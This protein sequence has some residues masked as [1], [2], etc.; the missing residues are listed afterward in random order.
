MAISSNEIN[1]R[2]S[3]GES[4]TSP[5]NSIGGKISLTSITDGVLNN[6][7]D[8][9]SDREENEEITDYR[10]IYILN[11]SSTDTFYD[12]GVWVDSQEPGGADITIG[13]DAVSE[14]QSITIFPE[15][16][17]VGGFFSLKLGSESTG[18][19][20]W[21]D[22]IDQMSQN[23]LV[24]LRATALLSNDIS[25]NSSISS[26]TRNFSVS[27]FGQEKNKTFPLMV[28]NIN[29]LVRSNNS[30]A[31]INTSKVQ[32]GKPIN[33]T[34]VNIGFSNNTPNN[35]S[36]FE[37]SSSS[38]L[39]IGVLKPNDFCYIWIRR[40]VP[41]YAANTDSYDDFVLKISGFTE[42]DYG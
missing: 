33:S 14:L 42:I 37:T 2:Y 41:S 39:E 8:D 17:I 12:V 15:S 10:A 11:N 38:K 19:I 23:I 24:A 5:S 7:F 26:N 29:N 32:Q 16:D 21:D 18:N 35:I 22:D 25:V 13:T 3:G 1:L 30:I 4:N 28:V 9:I 27:F 36:F 40:N 31:T 6:L 34:A 20:S